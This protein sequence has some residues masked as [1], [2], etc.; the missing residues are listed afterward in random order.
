MLIRTFFVFIFAISFGWRAL[1][2]DTPRIRLVPIL[3]GL[4]RPLA[5]VDDGSGRLFIVEQPGRIR[6]A[7]DG[8]FEPQPFL[9]IKDR[10]YSG[11]NECGLLGLAFHSEF[12]TN[13]R[14]FVNYTTKQ[15]GKLQTVVSEFHADASATR[16]NAA[17]E[18]EILRFDQPWA[19]H[20]GG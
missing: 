4:Q 13:H 15:R 2:A 5:C 18:R 9:D 7:R 8:Q 12:K 1:A 14:F 20:N 3:T 10:V 17:S 11:D 6:A 19:N 16:G